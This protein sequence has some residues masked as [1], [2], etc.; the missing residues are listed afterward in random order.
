[1]VARVSRV[2]LLHDALDLPVEER[3]QLA[4]DL[5]ATLDGPADADAHEAWTQE[6]RRRVDAVLAGETKTVSW[7]ELRE[8]LHHRWGK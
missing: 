2:E 8:K 4:A 5:L 7:P 3:A 6:I 1:M